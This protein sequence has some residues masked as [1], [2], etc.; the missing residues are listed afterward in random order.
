MLRPGEYRV[1]DELIEKVAVSLCNTPRS[2][3][4]QQETKDLISSEL[5][6][7]LFLS[8]ARGIGAM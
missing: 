5:M 2:Q 1:P 3:R 6:H 8:A 4:S 7:E